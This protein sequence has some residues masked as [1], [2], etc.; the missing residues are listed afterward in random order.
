M[1]ERGFVVV[2]GGLIGGL[3]FELILGSMFAGMVGVFFGVVLANW[4][5]DYRR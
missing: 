4:Y 3:L 5:W 2:F 1:E